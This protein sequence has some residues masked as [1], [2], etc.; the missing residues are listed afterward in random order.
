MNILFVRPDIPKETIGLQHV[1]I[2]EPLELEILATLIESEHHVEIVDLILEKN[3]LPF[4]IEKK[5][6]DIVCLTGYITH[7]NA[8]KELCK[9]IKSIN[10]NIVTIVGGVHIEK[11]PESVDSEF[12]DYRVV[13]N[14]VDV[15]PKLISYLKNETAFPEG[16][17]R[18]NEQ[19][20]EKKLPHYKF[21][22]PIPNRE[23]TKK[24]RK[25]YFY[26]FHNKVALLKCSFGCPFPCNFCFCRKITGDNYV[27]RDMNEVIEE[28][29]TIKE[30]EVYIIDDN[31]LVSEKRVQTFLQLLKAEQ[32]HKKYLIY[33]RADFIAQHPDII[34]DFKKQGL[35]TIIVGFESFNDDELSSL[36]KKTIAQTNEKAMK[37]LNDNG[38]DCYA[39][40]IVMPEWDKDDFARATKKML[41]LGI[42]FI[43]IQP[44]TPLEKTDFEF[45]DSRLIIPRAE[46]EKWDLAHLVIKPE[47]LSIIDYYKEIL[48]MYERVLFNPRNLIRHLKYP[49]NMQ[50]K[51]F[52]GAFKVRKQYLNK[53]LCRK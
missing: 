23:L 27:E 43:N 40:V 20:D 15:F 26:V 36:N 34:R 29:K 17:L 7:N 51:L 41:D 12:I 37:I 10:S 13:R 2:V 14:A 47:K 35:R 39:S 44:L 25:H 19:L 45:D 11:V 16:V 53:I 5:K 18:M 1:M 8:L 31:F 33:G 48:K 9:E 30:K 6:P 49:V 50:I 52:S 4:F 21:D 3:P 22:V 42:K 24:Y 38:V 32:I 46:Y 28:L